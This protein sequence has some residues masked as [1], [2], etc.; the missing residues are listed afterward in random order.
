M[1]EKVPLQRPPEIPGPGPHNG[2]QSGPSGPF[3]SS[4]PGKSAYV[5]HLSHHLKANISSPKPPTSPISGLARA[6]GG[7]GGG[8]PSRVGTTDVER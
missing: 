1:R 5:P 6:R 7:G 2:P 8:S 3:I 4:S